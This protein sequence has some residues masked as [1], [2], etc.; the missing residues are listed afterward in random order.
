MPSV[1][2]HIL[3]RAHRACL[4]LL[5]AVAVPAAAA[6]DLI[7]K[8]LREKLRAFD[9]ALGT[10]PEPGIQART[11]IDQAGLA[12]ITHLQQGAIQTAAV[13]TFATEDRDMV[14]ARPMDAR[15]ALGLIAQIYGAKDNLDILNAQVD[16]EFKA[17]VINS[18]DATL[19]D[20]FQLL[21]QHRLQVDRGQGRN[22]LKVP[23]IIWGKGSLRIGPG[24]S[25]TFL[26]DSG[27]FLANFGRLEIDGATV[28]V[29]GQA[30]PNAP[31]FIPFIVNAGGASVKARNSTFTDL[32]FGN[33]L[34]FGGFSVARN[35][36][37]VRKDEI[38]IEN[39]TFSNL[40]SVGASMADNV[41][42]RNNRIHNSRGAALVVTHSLGARI[43]GNLITG[44]APTNAIRLLQGS[45]RGVIAGN[46]I[47]RGSR[48][49]I[50]V[51]N[52]SQSVSVRNNVVW[53]RD[54]GGI[55]V[56]KSTC[57]V[58]E[59]NL[60]MDNDQKGIEIRTGRNMIVRDNTVIGNNSIGIWVSAQEPGA[61][62]L[63]DHNLL[64]G[65]DAGLATATGE[66]VVMTGN[67]FTRQFPRFVS[68]DLS[69]QGRVIATNLKGET[70]MILTAGGLQDGPLPDVSCVD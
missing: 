41:V 70:P 56:S 1:F 42:L 9:T 46:V 18:G 64:L 34:K 3:G 27:A 28:G 20:I 31:D 55:T 16:P 47:L 37:L 35:P 10:L 59:H 40:A 11:L 33:E 54:G 26:R 61:K 38:M 8:T 68:G 21:E 43:L 5:L 23:V 4:A 19:S 57:A 22:L 24:E 60:I 62:T 14:D 65:N 17:L 2:K 58:V 48:T 6:P 32:G 63:I 15:L 30:N 7:D 66:T 51:Q 50:V 29:E 67:D 45:S 36:L 49:G 13:Q 44:D 25:L 52:D 12:D 69:S 53:Q 39:N